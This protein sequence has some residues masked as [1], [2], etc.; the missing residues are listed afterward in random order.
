MFVLGIFAYPVSA[1]EDVLNTQVEDEEESRKNELRELLEIDLPAETDN[2]NYQIEFAEPDDTEVEIKV[3]DEDYAVKK[4]P[5][6]L[7]SLSIGRHTITF[8][9]EDS[10][11]VEQT[12]EEVMIILPREPVFSETEDLSF[13]DGAAVTF[14]GTALPNSTLVFLISS[15]LVMQIATTDSDGAWSFTVSETL[16]QGNHQ[17]VGFVRKDGYASDFSDPVSFYVGVAQ[18]TELEVGKSESVLPFDIN[19]DLSQIFSESN[20]YYFIG[21]GGVVLLIA[22]VLLG[23]NIK[24]GSGNKK[25]KEKID[26]EKSDGS[27]MTLREKL[28]GA[29]KQE[30]NKEGKSSTPETTTNQGGKTEG[31]KGKDDKG[32]SKRDPIPRD[33]GSRTAGESLKDKEKTKKQWFFGKLFGGKKS[34]KS[35]NENVEEVKKVVS[36]EEFIEDFKP[37]TAKDAEKDDHKRD[38]I[39]PQAGLQDSQPKDSKETSGDKKSEDKASKSNKIEVTLG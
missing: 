17:I 16:D 34:D 7:P 23:G 9:F 22:L 12:L 5:Y 38:P 10:E 24:T 11:E 18:D 31:K 32:K 30:K 29:V 35:N 37:S 39:A 33:A 3:D 27:G 15:D 2:P 14:S 19:I 25:E 1:Q 8:K 13:D 26:N 20:K 21:A 6:T 4:S 36:K 28:S